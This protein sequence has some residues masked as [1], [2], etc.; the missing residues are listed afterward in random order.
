[1][2][3]DECYLGGNISKFLDTRIFVPKPVDL[4]QSP[5]IILLVFDFCAIDTLPKCEQALGYILRV[6]IVQSRG[7]TTSSERPYRF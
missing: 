5:I 2:N 7:T 3:E 4:L 6:I 1:M